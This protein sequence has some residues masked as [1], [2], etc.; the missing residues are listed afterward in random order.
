[1]TGNPH[2][3]M[4]GVTRRTAGFSLVEM[5]IVILIAGIL[6]G[7]VAV[8]LVRPIEGYRD[9]SRRAALV[10]AAEN[11]LRRMERDI[12]IALPNSVRIT[13]LGGGGF[14]LE[15]LPTLDGALYRKR[16]GDGSGGNN[17]L[18]AGNNDDQF[19]IHKYF[20]HITVPSSST[21]H[22]LVVDNLGTNV[23]E[24]N[25]YFATG[26]PAV[27]TP[28]GTTISYDTS[29]INNAHHVTMTPQHQ[30]RG[31]SPRQRL[32]IVETPVTYLCSPNAT[33]PA[34][35]TLI[36]Y[37]SYPITAAQPTDPGAAP[38]A[39]A[40]SALVAG[41]VS[42]CSAN[43]T[44]TDVR[45]RGLATLVLSVEEEGEPVRLVHQV[46]LDNSR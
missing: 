29:G 30:F 42:V 38:L 39:T 7:I 26:S 3:A 24:D 6:A 14:A 11:A 27:I 16:G 46:Q 23:S 36:R 18:N 25:A 2:R 37:E 43:T 21:A 31:D 17:R 41:R 40:T 15:T 12:R 34:L 13:N 45:N 5:V 20:R 10:D 9:L 28:L 19:D 44:D 32:Y 33:D 35:G 1:M 22:R 8:F 4:P